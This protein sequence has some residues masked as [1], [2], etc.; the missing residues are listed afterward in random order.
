NGTRNDDY[1][2]LRNDSRTSPAVLAHLAAENAWYAQYKARYQPLEDKLFAEMKSRVKE[3]DSTVPFELLGDWYATRYAAGQEYPIHV[4]HRG[5][6]D[7][8]EQ[9]LLDVNELAQGKAY[10]QVLDWHV[11]VGRQVLAYSE[12]D[13]GRPQYVIRFRDLKTGALLPDAMPG[14]SGSF[15]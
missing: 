8:S 2:W 1:Y 10:C 14:T 7:A 3:Y 9:V 6:A 4:W 11:S 12:Y 5:S 15:A 13:V